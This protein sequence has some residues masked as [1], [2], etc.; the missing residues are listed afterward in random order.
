MGRSCWGD[1]GGIVDRLLC[2]IGRGRGAWDIATLG[3]FLAKRVDWRGVAANGDGT[4]LGTWIGAGG[5]GNLLRGGG[6]CR[7]RGRVMGAL[8]DVIISP[9]G[10]T[11]LVRCGDYQNGGTRLLSLAVVGVMGAA[12]LRPAACWKRATRHVNSSRDEQW[13]WAGIWPL[14]VA[15]SL[16]AATMTASS[17][18]T[19]GLEMYLCL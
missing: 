8:G 9:L 14:S 17:E 2:Q 1:G 19:T 5:R 11:C 13:R 16:P 4:T 12:G 18:V 7:F 10:V 15:A 3:D 6:M